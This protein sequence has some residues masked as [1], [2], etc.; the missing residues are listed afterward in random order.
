MCDAQVQHNH[1]SALQKQIRAPLVS[2]EVANSPELRDVE[3]M[4]TS[5]V[6]TLLQAFKALQIASVTMRNALEESLPSMHGVLSKI[7]NVDRTSLNMILGP[8]LQDSQKVA[9]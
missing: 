7:G 4:E 9:Q 6:P 8:K 1:R 2:A 3:T 5:F